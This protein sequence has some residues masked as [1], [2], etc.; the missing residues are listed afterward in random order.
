MKINRL[1]FSGLLSACLFLNGQG[2]DGFAKSSKTQA[3]TPTKITK[4]TA[5]KL[6]M[7]KIS[8]PESSVYLLGS[9]HLLKPDFY[10]LPAEVEEAF[11]SMPNLAVEM[12]ETTVDKSQMAQVSMKLGMYPAGDCLEDHISPRTKEAFQTF[13]QSGTYP[14]ALGQ[15]LQSQKPWLI[16][17]S[18]PVLEFTRRGFNPALGIDKHFIDAAHSGGKKVMELESFEFQV[19]LLSGFDDDIQDKLLFQTLQEIKNVDEYAKLMV[20]AWQK[21]DLDAMDS[22]ITRDIK[23]YP[24]LVPVLE[25]VIWE[26]NETMAEKIDGYLQKK[27]PV[28]VVVGSGHLCGKRGLVSLLKKRGYKVDQVVSKAK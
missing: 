18:I 23:D 25:K 11:R 24:E 15:A 27:Q 10:P 4:P 6:Y 20:T 8:S 9:I 26:R 16:S 3:K 13:L 5:N 22:L 12:D 21:G 19:N 14:S 2:Q 7:F 17:I 1:I 28:F